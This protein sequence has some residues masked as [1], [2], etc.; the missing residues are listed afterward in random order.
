MGLALTAAWRDPPHASPGRAVARGK[1]PSVALTVTGDRPKRTWDQTHIWGLS[2]LSVGGRGG[3]VE[4][5]CSK[6]KLF[7]LPM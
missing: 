4:L 1:G 2:S 6:T 7:S 5:V 3:C